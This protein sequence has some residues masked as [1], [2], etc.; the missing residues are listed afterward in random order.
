MTAKDALDADVIVVGGGPAGSVTA[1]LLAERGHHV[2]LL[3]KA[4]FPRHKP[5]SE[6]VNPAGARIL[7]DL[8]LGR[9]LRTLG[10]HRVAFMAIHAPNGQRFLVDFE[11]ATPGEC[12]LGLS[13]YRL[14]ALLLDRARETGVQVRE[15]AHVRDLVAAEGHVKG[16][17]ATIDGERETLRARLIIGA[18][19]RHSVVARA[20]D[21]ETP[22]RWPR[23]TGLIAHYRGVT[24]L[25]R[26]GEMHVARHGYA[27]LAPLEDGLTN[28]AFVTDSAAV[29]SRPGTL[30]EFFVAGLDRI[31]AVAALLTGAEQQGGIRG[32]GPMAH[33]ALRLY[34]DGYLLVGD[35]AGF[36]DPFTGDGIYEA[37]RGALLAA[38]VADAA[39][40]KGDLSARSLAPYGAARERVFRAKRN[41]RWLVQGFISRPA[42]LDYAAGRLL[43]RPRVAATLTGV[44]GDLLPAEAALSPR[45]LAQLLRP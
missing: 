25:D 34:G 18:D 13:R 12:A 43:A 7:G 26:G 23:R 41:V 35:A 17:V 28:V 44:L 24:G 14:D 3:D 21:L 39:L 40:R 38:P 27:G 42:L 45:F 22:L 32:V 10:A 11:T 30:E 19:G 31:P 2:L 20:L 36:L 16:V 4:R 15:G 29:A 1:A 9:E 8:G 37:M 6:Y 5:C 33:R